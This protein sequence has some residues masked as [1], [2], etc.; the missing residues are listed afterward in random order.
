MQG[1]FFKFLF[2]NEIMRYCTVT[3]DCYAV[4]EECLLW[5]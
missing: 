3:L 2:L 5:V 1:K 4:Q